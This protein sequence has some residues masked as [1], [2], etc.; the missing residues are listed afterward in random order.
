MFKSKHERNAGGSY[1]LDRSDEVQ[2]EELYSQST[3]LHKSS[4]R[5]NQMFIKLHQHLMY[6]FSLP[7]PQLCSVNIL[8]DR[9]IQY[10]IILALKL[11]QEEHS[12][13]Q[14]K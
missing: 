9:L 3:D 12:T 13:R 14:F 8:K 4:T 7:I 10:I 6:V 11:L 2:M 1:C 5:E